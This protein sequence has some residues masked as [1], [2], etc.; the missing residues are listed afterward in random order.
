MADAVNIMTYASAT[1]D[2]KPG[3]A[4]WNLFRAQVAGEVLVLYGETYFNWSTCSVLSIFFTCF[5]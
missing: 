4:V 5:L 1:P 3:C 2:G